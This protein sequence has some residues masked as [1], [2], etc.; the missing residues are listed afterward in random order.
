M[1]I[2]L[3][4]SH[5]RI[6]LDVRASDDTVQAAVAE[7]QA[8]TGGDALGEALAASFTHEAAQLEDVGE[9]R[10]EQ[11]RQPGARGP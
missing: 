7:R 6:D 9:V 10:V 8:A 11:K 2:D 5:R 4:R 3:D 1:L